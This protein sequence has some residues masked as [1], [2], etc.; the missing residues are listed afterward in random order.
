MTD[1]DRLPP[2]E[3]VILGGDELTTRTMTRVPATKENTRRILDQA[4]GEGCFWNEIESLFSYCDKLLVE[5][6]WVRTKER[7]GWARE[8]V[9]GR[10]G[11]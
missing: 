9:S 6:G 1:Q 8:P 2:P 7:P 3:V 10:T 4:Y 11:M 5:H